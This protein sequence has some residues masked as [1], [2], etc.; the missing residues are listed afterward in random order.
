M[1]V[2][3]PRRHHTSTIWLEGPDCGG[4]FRTSAC[5]SA[6]ESGATRSSKRFTTPR[7]MRLNSTGSPCGDD[8][9]GARTPPRRAAQRRRYVS[10][11]DASNRANTLGA[12]ERGGG[13][14]YPR[15][16]KAHDGLHGIADRDG[17]QR[18]LQ[19]QAASVRV[20]NVHLAR[21]VVKVVVDV[22][23]VEGRREPGRRQGRP[24]HTA[25][26]SGS[27]S[28]QGWRWA[29]QIVFAYPDR[30]M[31]AN[32]LVWTVTCI[33]RAEISRRAADDRRSGWTGRAAPM[34]PTAPQ[35]SRGPGGGLRSRRPDR[36]NAT[37]GS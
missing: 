2:E 27:V 22:E 12:V 23:V 32:V 15:A 16:A 36:W 35:R 19:H 8:A 30:L 6:E 33:I 4:R 29:T 17:L 9:G 37:G 3:E 28:V 25:H 21:G 26:G 11:R 14:P 7:K 5:E 18:A 34:H 20:P 10:T 31:A 1:H 13:S 24:A